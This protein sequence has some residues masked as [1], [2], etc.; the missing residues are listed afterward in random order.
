ML[1]QIRP[2]LLLVQGDTMT[3]FAS[4][5]AAHLERIPVGHVE[6]GLRTGDRYRPF[7]E[8]MNRVL[9]TRVAALHFAPTERA[10]EALLSEGVP[11]EDVYLTG[12]TVIDALLQTVREDYRFRDSCLAG[13]DPERRVVLVTAHRR[14]SFGEPLREICAAVAE[15]A[16]EFPDADFVLPVHP[17]PEVRGT[18]E[19][20]GRGR[21]NVFV[22]DPIEY[23]DFANLIARAY[24]ILTDSGGIQEEAPSLGK[25]VLVLREV[26]ERPEGIDAG[27][28]ILVGTEARKITGKTRELLS[29]AAAYER[30][31]RAVNPYGDGRASTRIVDALEERFR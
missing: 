9:A 10:R 25:P 7:P 11:A 21:S 14:E 26:T 24:L 31:A 17:N 12:N 4:A 5:L 2:D 6:A 8:E 1:R 29:D 27:T 16:A 23:E 13:L 30:M 19:P 15:L 3:T 20:M 22:V 28:A 18:V